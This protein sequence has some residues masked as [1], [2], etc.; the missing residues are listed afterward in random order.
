MMLA[1]E[2]VAGNDGDWI[3]VRRISTDCV[4]IISTFSKIR[5]G[6][7]RSEWRRL[8]VFGLGKFDEC[9]ETFF[10]DCWNE[11]SGSTDCGDRL[12]REIVVRV[13]DVHLRC[14]LHQ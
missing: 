2:T 4:M 11:L 6:E 8:T 13:L 12:G 7:M 5:I 9:F 3:S 1:F 10:C 14:A